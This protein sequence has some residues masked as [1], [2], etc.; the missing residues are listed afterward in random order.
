MTFPK[1]P[2]LDTNPELQRCPF[3]GTLA[4]Y[5]EDGHGMVRAECA[6][7]SCA[8]A[9]PYHYKTRE[10]AKAAWNRSPCSTDSAMY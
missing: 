2:R 8:V 1:S 10:A 9:T 6:N 7:G 3:C 4:G 5:R